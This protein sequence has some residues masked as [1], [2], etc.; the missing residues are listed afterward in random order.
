MTLPT[1]FEPSMATP[2]SLNPLITSERTAQLVPAIRRPLAKTSGDATSDPFNTMAGPLGL[3]LVGSV[4]PSMIIPLTRL[5]RP[6]VG[7][8]LNTLLLKPGSL[9]GMLNVI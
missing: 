9:V 8:M 7:V 1:A 4:L 2:L 6:A 5:R 3:E